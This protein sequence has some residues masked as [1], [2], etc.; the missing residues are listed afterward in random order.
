MSM[1]PNPGSAV[2]ASGYS[3]EP[4]S[5]FPTSSDDQVSNGTSYVGARKALTL[6]VLGLFP[7]SILTGIP[8]IFLG[9]HAL[10][11]IRAS[12]GTLTGRSFAWTG[13]VLGSLS[14]PA[15]LAFIYAVHH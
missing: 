11:R 8:A 2:F 7:L 6:G 10:R 1:V 14:V 5:G 15:F 9:A 3:A 12:A 4:H 13:I